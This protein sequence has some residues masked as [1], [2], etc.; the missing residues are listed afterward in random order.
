MSFKKILTLNVL[1]ASLVACGGGDINIQPS[2]TSNT[3]GTSS[4]GGSSSNS[5]C[6]AYTVGGTTFQ[7]TLSGNNCQYNT[8]FVDIDNP[9]TVDVTF[10]ALPNNGVHVFAGSLVVGENFNTDAGLTA[11]GITAGGDGP[12]LAIGAG[13]TLAFQSSDDFMVINRGSQIVANGTP[14]APIT[15]TS[16]TDAVFGTVGPEDVQQWG[17][18]VINGFGV[19]NKCAYTGTRGTD[20]A[21]AG[22][23]HVVAEGQASAGETNYGGNNDA[24]NSGTMRY[25]VVKHTGAE[26]APGNELNGIAF[27]AVGSGTT[28]EFLEVYSVYDDGIEFFGGAVDI[29]NY[30][31]VYAKDDSID[32][33]EGYRGTIT[34]AL[35]IQS[36]TDGN[37]CV[38][39]DGIGSYSDVSATP[40]AVADLMAR[41]LN[42][43]ATILNMT[44]IVS[45]NEV[46]THDPGAGLRI[47]EAHVPIIRNSIVTTAYSGDE[48]LGD[49]DFNWCVRI[50][51]EGGPAALA[52]DLE[53]TNTVLACQDLIDGDLGGGSSTLTWLDTPAFNNATYQSAE[54]GEDP[55]ETSNTNLEIL[56]GFYSLLSTVPAGS[57]G[58]D[59]IMNINGETVPTPAG[60]TY[61]GAVIST[62]DWTAGWTYGL[63]PGS[64]AQALWFE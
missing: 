62:D 17:G 15:I 59:G 33:D 60:E 61:I 56:D 34:N 11:A 32:I 6:A 23:C 36:E 7:G 45:A 47:R 53:I 3:T 54:A 41:G 13:S 12:T 37:R 52:G 38:E 31:A 5:V 4:T 64:R 30:V 44:C 48:K 2:V 26:V 10:Q 46:G 39:S 24:D 22:E 25:V 49:D 8:S 57:P 21:L 18:L 43:A 9:L 29:D 27:N 63:H 55:T 28:V 1:A 20:L 42:S 51:E 16:Q 50:D 19:T 14:V 58:A 40:G 35:V